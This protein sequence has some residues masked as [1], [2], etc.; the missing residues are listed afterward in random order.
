M[1]IFFLTGLL[2]PLLGFEADGLIRLKKAGIS[3]NIIEMVLNEKLFETCAL[4]AD[5]IIQLKKAGFTDT[6]ISAYIWRQ[7]FL[8][9]DKIKVYTNT[10][11]SS[12]INRVTLE[13]LE[14]LK[15]DGFSD[16]IIKAVIASQTDGYSNSEQNHILKMF[17]NMELSVQAGKSEHEFGQ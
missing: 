12:S 4:T 16:D 6:L 3:E 2:N 9:R 13:D 14:R 1:V 10:R 17:E 8:G 5:D 7:S 15:E 11:D